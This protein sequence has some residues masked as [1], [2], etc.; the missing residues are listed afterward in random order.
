MQITKLS[1]FFLA[2]IVFDLFS[3][4][5]SKMHFTGETNMYIYA[6]ILSIIREFWRYKCIYSKDNMLLYDISAFMFYFIFYFFY[7]LDRFL[8]NFS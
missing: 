4:E 7:K 3:F 8:W 1:L 6:Y 2:L 5:G